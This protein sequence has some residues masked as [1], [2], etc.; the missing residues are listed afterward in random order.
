MAVFM[1]CDDTVFSHFVTDLPQVGAT[2]CSCTLGLFEL[3]MAALR[4]PEAWIFNYRMDLHLPLIL[5][6]PEFKSHGRLLSR[7]FTLDID[8]KQ[9][10]TNGLHDYLRSALHTSI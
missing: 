4:R 10:W 8:V 3:Q 1:K 9:L 6:C 7:K 2:Y 5:Y